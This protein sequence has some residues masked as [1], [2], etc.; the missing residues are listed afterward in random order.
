MVVRWKSRFFFQV[1]RVISI[2]IIQELTDFGLLAFKRP[3]GDQVLN[4]FSPKLKPSAVE[5][6]YQIAPTDFTDFDKIKPFAN[7]CFY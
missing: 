1:C 2:V 7:F 6:I 3:L 5:L 4:G